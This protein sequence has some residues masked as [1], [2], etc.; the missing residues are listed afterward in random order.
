MIEVTALT[1]ARRSTAW[2]AFTDPTHV[3]NWNF[4]GDDWC[5]PSCTNDVRVGGTWTSR[6]EARDG[7]FGF[8]FASTYTEV[9][10][11]EKIHL[12]MADGRRWE[13][14]FSDE[15]TGTRIT[16]RFDPEAQNP[17]DMQ[18]AGW[19]MILDRFATYA[20]GL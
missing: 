11:G 3:V 6:M 5:C 16:E 9:V 19:Q 10:E 14:E 4:A 12:L 13:V 7:S 20:S 18:R 1:S 2:H 15:G 17:E 8:D